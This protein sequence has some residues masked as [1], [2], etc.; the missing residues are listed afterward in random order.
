MRYEWRQ[1]R[2]TILTQVLFSTIAALLPHLS[3]GWSTMGHRGPKALCLELVL[4]SSPCLLL[5]QTVR[6]PGYIIFWHPPASAVLLIIHTAASLDW[7][8]GQGSIHNN[9]P[10][11]I[12]QNS[13]FSPRLSPSFSHTHLTNNAQ[14]QKQQKYK[15]KLLEQ[16]LNTK[17]LIR[18]RP[19]HYVT[20]AQA[21]YY[22]NLFNNILCA[23]GYPAI[24]WRISKP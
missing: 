20:L 23:V 6:A 11:L 10:I 3:L 24:P 15:K 1:G 13:T 14:W 9:H 22:L 4:T 17:I 12:F 8:L 7:R 16:Q 18:M 21:N 5:S 2:T 19:S